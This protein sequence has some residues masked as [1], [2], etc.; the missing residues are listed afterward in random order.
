[1]RDNM[2]ISIR[3]KDGHF[4]GVDLNIEHNINYQKVNQFNRLYFIFIN[5]QHIL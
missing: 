3:G 1:M 4:M 5:V 2:L